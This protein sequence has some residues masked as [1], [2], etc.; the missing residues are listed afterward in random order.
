ML[1]LPEFRRAS[2]FEDAEHRPFGS[3]GSFLQEHVLHGITV[4]AKSGF[5]SQRLVCATYGVRE[6]CIVDAEAEP[7]ER[8]V[9]EEGAFRLLLK[10]GSGEIESR[11][12]PGFRIP[13]RAI[14]DSATNPETLRRLLA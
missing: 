5:D 2:A 3:R 14:F 1:G 7:V 4:L 11:V 9:L 8:D 6:S 10:S 13:I 12:V